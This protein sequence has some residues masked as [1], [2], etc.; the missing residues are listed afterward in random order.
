[1]SFDRVAPLYRTLERFV[2]GDQLQQA[3]LAFLSEI[4]TPHRVLV[5]GEGDGRFLAEFVRRYPEAEIDCLDVSAR[6][7]ALARSRLG[8]RHTV[9]FIQADLWDYSLEAGRYDL[10]VTHFFLDCFTGATLGEIIQKLANA[11]SVQ[12][13]WLLA[14]FR[15][16]DSGWRRFHARFWI[17]SM[18]LFFRLTSGLEAKRLDDPSPG[19]RTA[20][21]ERHRQSLTRSAMVKSELWHRLA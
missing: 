8:E 14:D 7:I 17:R 13:V 19:L 20:G 10:I 4:E 1:M 21:F 16:P 9:N 2:F 11:A 5:V 12:A 15:L 6:M 18:Y 3:R